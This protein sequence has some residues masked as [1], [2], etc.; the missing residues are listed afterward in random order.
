[1]I[2]ARALA[3]VL[4][5]AL[6]GAGCAAGGKL[7]QNAEVVRADV[8]KAKRS[9]ALRCAPKELAL[10]DSNVDI[11]EEEIAYGHGSRAK[12]HLDLAERSAK[13][14]LE[15]SRSCGPAQVTVAKRAPEPPQK[16]V[17]VIEK[18]DRDGDGIPDLEDRCPELAGKPAFGGCPD[19][20]DDGVADS[21]DACPK[22]AGPKETQGCPV[23]KDSDHDGVPDDIDRCPLDAEDKDGFQDEDGCPDADNDNDGIVDRT[24]ACPDSPGTLE[25]RGC[26]VVDRDGDGV[27]DAEDRCADVKGLAALGGCPDG[28]ADGLADPE[29]KC[30]LNAG[31]KENGGCPDV[32]R[33]GDTVPDR[34]DKCADQFGP[35][36]EGCPKKYSLVEVKREKIE[37]KQQVHF[38]SAKSRVLADS[39]PL[40]NQVVQ[41]LNDFPKMRVS[42]EGHTDTVGAEAGNMRLSQRRSD[43]V[44]D[45]LASKGV[46]ADRLETVGYGPTKP[47]ASNKT[48]RGRARNRRTEFRIVSLE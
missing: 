16:P 5:V 3:P 29:D 47:V 36:P 28:D 48:E 37:I 1:V 21:E 10:A 44:R 39:F 31:P 45:Y 46:A 40:L 11:A 4:V 7:R 41:V 17:V 2:R 13:R 26:P 14:A 12:D 22:E 8:E 18:T 42:I 34:L 9:G 15:L 30:P 19:S 20:D 33:D 6:A 35:A 38:A 27:A 25:N 43:A 23:S 32:D 24:D